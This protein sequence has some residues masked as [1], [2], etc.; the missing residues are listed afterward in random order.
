LKKLLVSDGLETKLPVQK[1]VQFADTSLPYEVL[2]KFGF[3]EKQVPELLKLLDAQSGSYLQNETYRIIRHGKWFIFSPLHVPDV[4]TVVFE[5]EV[6]RTRL[7]IGELD[8]KTIPAAHFHLDKAPAVAQLDASEIQ[9]PLIARHWKQGDYFYPLG[10][11][12]KKK[13]ARF[14]IDLK[15]TPTQ[16]ENIWVLESHA[17]I[18]WIIG[19][20]IDDRF[21]VTERTKTILQLTLN[22]R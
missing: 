8:V 22:S 6:K 21:K 19:Y 18:I 1:L 10:M 4:S 2:K 14:F 17:R 20:R 9:Y 12:K 5:K 13:L 15:L 16:K 7:P 3:R 11:R